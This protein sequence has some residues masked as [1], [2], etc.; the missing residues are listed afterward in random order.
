MKEILPLGQSS[1]DENS[2]MSSSTTENK[3]D[4]SLILDTEEHRAGP[5]LSRLNFL[6]ESCPISPMQSVT[7]GPTTPPSSSFDEALTPTEQSEDVF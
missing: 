3:G 6:G 5:R 2:S 1:W 7:P 4:D